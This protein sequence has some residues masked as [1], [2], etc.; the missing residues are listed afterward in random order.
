[1]SANTKIPQDATNRQPVNGGGKAGGHSKF[2][3][4][5]DNS[6]SRESSD[7]DPGKTSAKLPDHSFPRSNRGVQR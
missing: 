4:M 3:N 5:V 7:N 1:M 2:Y 6:T